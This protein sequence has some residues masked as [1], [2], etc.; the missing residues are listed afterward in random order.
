M[1]YL[2]HL[3]RTLLNKSSDRE[4]SLYRFLEGKK[5]TFVAK[6]N[7]LE[8]ALCSKALSGEHATN[9]LA[10]LKKIKP[11]KGFHYS[12]NLITLVAA[13]LTSKETE[14]VYITEYLHSHSCRDLYLIGKA[15]NKTFELKPIPHNVVDEV[16]EK[17]LNNE[18]INQDDIAKCITQITD[19]F[20][21]FVVKQAISLSSL[22]YEKSIKIPLYEQLRVINLKITKRLDLFFVLIGSLIF[23]WLLTFITPYIVTYATKNWDILE[24]LAYLLDKVLLVIGFLG[25]YN[26]INSVKAKDNVTKNFFSVCYLLLGV[27]YSELTNINKGLKK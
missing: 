20:D 9:E 8:D 10:E 6:Q 12:N 21:M 22:Q 17:I 11:F 25:A 4:L 23:C 27:K 1:V 24:P 13:S 15:L 2:E 16:A 5:H 19:L 7:D 14:S 26:F 3:E 18:I